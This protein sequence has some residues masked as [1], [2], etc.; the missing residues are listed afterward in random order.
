MTNK[1]EIVQ[2][3]RENDGFQYVEMTYQEY[4]DYKYGKDDSPAKRQEVLNIC[5]TNCHVLVSEETYDLCKTVLNDAATDPRLTKMKAV[6]F[7]T[8]KPKGKRNKNNIIKDPK[9][10]REL[11]DLAFSLGVNVGF[12]SC[13]APIFLTAMKDHPQFNRFSQMTESCESN[14]F[15]GYAN[16]DGNYWHC[17]FTEDQPGWRAIS[18]LDAT[19]F[20]KDIWHSPEVEK[21]RNRLVSQDNSHIDNE[22]YLCPV[23]DLYDPSIG[24]AAKKVINVEAM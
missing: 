11:I 14:R 13:T 22:C 17:S 4:V 9:K 20:I 3:R 1:I 7:L 2:E 23:Y 10:Y 18:L 12:D 6:M 24:C 8:L 21:F 15:S 5:S 19:D 16:V